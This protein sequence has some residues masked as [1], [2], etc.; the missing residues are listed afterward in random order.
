MP[1]YV[2]EIGTPTRVSTSAFGTIGAGKSISL[3]GVGV[4][5]VLTSQIVNLYVGAG[6]TSVQLLGTCT[7]AANSFLAVPAYCSGGLSYR[8]TNEDVDLTIYWNPEHG[9]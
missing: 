8:V 1:N 6:G 3:V 4:A 7:L 9:N 2:R 5:S